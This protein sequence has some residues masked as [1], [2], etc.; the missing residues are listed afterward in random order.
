MRR[1][2]G[3]VVLL[4]AVMVPA[5][6]SA[7]GRLITFEETTIEGQIDKPEAF[8]ILSPTNLEYRAVSPEASFL[9]KIHESTTEPVFGQ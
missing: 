8:Y 6:A 2:L 3:C 9:E 7:Q 1:K 5:F 4:M